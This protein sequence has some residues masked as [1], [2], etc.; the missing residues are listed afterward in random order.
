VQRAL[1]YEIERQ[2]AMLDAG[3]R[4]VQETRGWVE[5]ERRTVSQRSKEEANDY[6]YF[7]EPDLPPLHPSRAWVEQIRALLPELPDARRTRF[8]NDFGLGASEAQQLTASRARADYYE[9]AVSAAGQDRAKAVANWVLGDLARLQNL[10]G[11]DIE[12]VAVRP[13]HLARLVAL[14]EEK[15][16]TT[17]GARQVIERMFETGAEPDAVVKELDLAPLGDDAELEAVIERVIE[18]NPKPVTDYR[19]GKAQALQALVGPVMRETRG[20]ARP[21]RVRELLQARL[22]RP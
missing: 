7:P 18:A 20:R 19:A 9:R 14:V 1:E 11:R 22:D 2:T 21:D 15:T 4:I 13:E 5:D 6:R 12:D 17:A 8:M 3:E 16:V 10:S